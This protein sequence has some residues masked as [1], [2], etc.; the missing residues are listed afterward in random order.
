MN[1]WFFNFYRKEL[2]IS[3][4]EIYTLSIRLPE[5]LRERCKQLAA[6]EGLSLNAF[7]VRTLDEK[8]EGVSES[9]EEMILRRIE[10]LEKAVFGKSK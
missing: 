8:A 1:E 9:T 4:E 10:K 2:K 3:Q 5:K 6:R 7:I